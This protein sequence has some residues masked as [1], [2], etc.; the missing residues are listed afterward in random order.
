MTP[1]AGIE[2]MVRCD[3]CFW[4]EKV[5]GIKTRGLPGFNLNTNTVTLLK[6]DLDP[7]QG[8]GLKLLMGTT[9]LPHLTP[10]CLENTGK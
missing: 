7:V 8:K 2:K 3:A 10:F 5:E 9:E 4:L 1:H 6:K